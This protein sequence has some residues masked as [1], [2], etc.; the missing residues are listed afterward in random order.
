MRDLHPDLLARLKAGATTLCTC[1]T[2][3]RRDGV[4][5]GFTDHDR[6][7]VL[8]GLVH[9]PASAWTTSAQ[10]LS[11]GLAAGNGEVAGALM[12]EAISEAD[13]ASGQYDGAG[14]ERWL[15][16]WSEPHLRVL[17][18]RGSLGEIVREGA[19]FRAE[20]LGLSAAL[21]RPIG[22]VFQP[23]CDARFG[24]VR[25]GVD[26]SRPDLS[27]VASV[28]TVDRLRVIVAG[29]DGVANGWFAGGTM[30][31]LTGVLAG[32]SVGIAAD[33]ETRDGR[34]LTLSN[35]AHTSPAPGD[36]GRA[37]VGCDG[38]LETCADR[39]GNA[40]NFRGF[41]HMPGDAWVLA[42]YPAPGGRHDGGAL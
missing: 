29:L 4:I 8:D 32:R 38:C 17:L 2:V 40:R 21:N 12:S 25:C 7:V 13:V 30:A 35:D 34:M 42:P 22:R 14:V 9:A 1:W 3:E 18:F 5:L 23:R 15:V 31:W 39:F 37:T 24:D 10:E 16:D 33:D 6:A 19:A 41:P 28:V 36:T 27:G 26:A 11:L 20:V